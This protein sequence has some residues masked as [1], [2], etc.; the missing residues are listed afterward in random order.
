MVLE[1][2]QF[3]PLAKVGL[4]W[5]KTTASNL[6]NHPCNYEQNLKGKKM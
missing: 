5:K 3:E 4:D 6:V 1:T 2:I